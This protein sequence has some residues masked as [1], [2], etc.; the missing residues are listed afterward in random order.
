MLI[1]KWD[2]CAGPDLRTEAAPFLGVDRCCRQAPPGDCPVNALA[3]Q[4]LAS[5]RSLTRI[6]HKMRIS[7][8]K[9]S[10]CPSRTNC[11]ILA[12]FND[13]FSLALQEL[14]DEWHLA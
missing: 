14:S 2:P 11:P 3:Q 8:G 9:C 6:L 12:S 4:T 13:Q 10:V 1:A 5:V 7:M